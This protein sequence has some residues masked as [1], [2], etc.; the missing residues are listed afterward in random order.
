MEPWA[1]AHREKAKSKPLSRDS[2]GSTDA[3]LIPSPFTLHPSKKLPTHQPVFLGDPAE[4]PESLPRF[5]LHAVVVAANRR[6]TPPAGLHPFRPPGPR[7]R[8]VAPLPA[9][10]GRPTL[11]KHR[12]HRH[13]FRLSGQH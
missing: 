3:F 2:G 12:R 7:D 10:T 8:V 11:R 1:T 13:G 4:K 9:K 5:Q 6:R